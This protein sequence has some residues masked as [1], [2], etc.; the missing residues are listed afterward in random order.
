MN[1]N[2]KRDY[3]ESGEILFG[4]QSPGPGWIKL[5]GTTANINHNIAK[6]LVTINWNTQTSNFTTQIRAVAFGNGTWVAVGAGGQLRT[7][8]N[9]AVTWNTQTSNFGANLIFD[10]AFGN[11]IFVAG[12]DVGGGAIRTSTDA[13][14]WNTQTS[15]FGTT[16]IISVGF[17]NGVWFAGANNGTLRTSTDAVNWNTQ[18][19]LGIQINTFA[20][21]NGIYYSGGVSIGS[22]PLRISTDAI[23]WTTQ[24][25]QFGTS[26]A[27]NGFEF[28]NGTWVAVG[29]G[30]IL[31]TSTNNGVTW[32]TQT[33]QF[34]TSGINA[35]AFGNGTWVAVGD[36]GQ[37]R[38]STL[39]PTPTIT[40][41]AMSGIPAGYTPWLKT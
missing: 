7:S 2:L 18:A 6:K 30:A 3:Y 4:M 23:N 21:G 9:N 26:N 8:T 19:N 38:T 13:I 15:Q 22:D 37:L 33:S 17:G 31:R 14:N 35:V 41:P 27:I 1:K 12:G 11:G 34:G 29:S 20:F 25:S 36:N 39:L 32:N 10:V 24:T 5:D 28:A 16:G 40:L